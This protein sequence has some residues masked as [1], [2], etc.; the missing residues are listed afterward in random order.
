MKNQNWKAHVALLLVNTFYGANHVIAKGIMPTYLTPNVFILLRVTGATFLFS[1][2]YFFQK[3]RERIAKKDLPRVFACALF[4]VAVNQLF[5]F[6]GLNLSSSINASII[7]TLN[8]IIVVVLSYFLLKE[9]IT[10]T[11]SVGVILGAMG[12]ILLTLS[13]SS[14]NVNLAIGDVFLLINAMSY[15]VYLVIAKPL[16]NKYKPVTVITH[17][18]AIGMVYVLIFPPTIGEVMQT[19]FSV[20]HGVVL[21]KVLYVII[22]VT[23]FAYLLTLY[24]LK[25]LSPSVSSSYI[26]LQPVLVIVF[27]IFFAYIGFTEDY[28]DTITLQ[29]MGYMLL[30]F[31]GVYITRKDQKQDL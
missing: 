19:D 31:L 25:R 24:G 6:H 10:K 21:G 16:M 5:F 26:Y 11:R 3:N 22:G 15:A 14:R 28:T 12:A 18:F 8:P 2:L 20:L 29:K 9:S 13:S 17:V 27:A 23:F 1:I 4:G 7:M 30:I